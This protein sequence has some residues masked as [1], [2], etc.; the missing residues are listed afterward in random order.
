LGH[1]VIVVA[2]GAQLALTIEGNVYRVP[3]EQEGRRRSF[4]EKVLRTIWLPQDEGIRWVPRVVS[5]AARWKDKQPVLFSTSPPLTTHLAALRLKLRYGWKW[6]ADFRDP[7]VGNPFRKQ[8]HVIYSDRILERLF[9]RY[10]DA[11]IANTDPVAELWRARYP[12]WRGKVH[13][14]WNGFDPEDETGSRPLPAR[15]YRVLA[16][17]G[18]M[19]GDR[20][21]NLVLSSVARLIQQ[22]LLSPESLRI[23]LTGPV[24]PRAQPDPRLA[25]SLRKCACL[26]INAELVPRAEAGRLIA[27][28]DE[29]LLLDVL[30]AKAGLQVPGKL[31]EYVRIGRP[32]LASTTEDSPVERILKASGVPYTC[33]YENLSEME[34][35]RRVLAF[36]N[37]PVQPVSPSPWFYETCSAGEQ[38]RKLSALVGGSES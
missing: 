8:R 6:I 18:S 11:L 4:A 38:A 19:Y 9:F 21:P 25:E 24:A 30:N 2:S 35:D 15:P 31:F 23:Q 5:L 7:L 13:V 28:A 3:G 16:H 1:S 26:E 29:L 10:A 37:L 36:L 20:H 27:E 14:L 22:G 34:I 17:V 33:I 12:Q 32:I